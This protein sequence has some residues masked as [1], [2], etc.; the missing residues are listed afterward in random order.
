MLSQIFYSY[1]KYTQYNPIYLKMCM[2]CV[3]ICKGQPDLN[4]DRI[5]CKL[6]IT[7]P[8]YFKHFQIALILDSE[9][10]LPLI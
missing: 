6:G 3:I 8:L 10:L 7:F 9:H 4:N 1:R 2:L 5:T